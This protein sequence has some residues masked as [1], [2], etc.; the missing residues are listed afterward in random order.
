[1]KVTFF[2]RTTSKNKEKPVKIR[3]QLRDGASIRIFGNSQQ[4]IAPKNWSNKQKKPIFRGNYDYYGLKTKLN[5]IEREIEKAYQKE[6]NKKDLN[7]DWL[8]EVIDRTLY[9]EKYDDS[10]TLF[11]FIEKF[12]EEAKTTP[13][14]KTGR[15]VSYKQRRLYEQTF[16]DLKTF[17]KQK[18]REYNWNDIDLDFYYDFMD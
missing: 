10:L 1:M 9:P 15:P 3:V 18:G 4:Y 7:Q 14:P 11:Q 2:I 5:L 12:I 6:P 17:C 16:E 8:N 13:N